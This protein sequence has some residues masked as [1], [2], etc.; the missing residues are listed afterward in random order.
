[1]FVQDSTSTAAGV[2]V[3]P[4]GSFIAPLAMSGTPAAEVDVAI[5]PKLSINGVGYTASAAIHTTT[6]G[7]GASAYTAVKVGDTVTMS[8]DA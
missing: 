3:H 5:T 6:G 7:A 8:K 2:A 4:Y 1:M